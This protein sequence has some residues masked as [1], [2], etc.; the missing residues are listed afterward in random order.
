LLVP[1][2][3]LN[4]DQ[5]PPTTRPAT[6]LAGRR[7]LTIASALL[8]G[9][10]FIQRVRVKPVHAAMDWSSRLLHWL[11]YLAIVIQALLMAHFVSEW[12]RT[13]GASR[14]QPSAKIDLDAM[15]GFACLALVFAYLGGRQVR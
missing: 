7:R 15:L 1:N 5:D 2:T 11:P 6:Y 3:K 13:T 14:Q 10:V 9:S 8:I 4:D 12:S